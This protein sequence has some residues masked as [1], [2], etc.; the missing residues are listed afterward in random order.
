M[1]GRSSNGKE[2]MRLSSSGSN[3][4]ETSQSTIDLA[5]GLKRSPLKKEHLDDAES[6]EDNELAPTKR[7]KLDL[8]DSTHCCAHMPH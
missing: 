3:G 1:K 8:P 4:A 6:V 7:S 5:E 2:S